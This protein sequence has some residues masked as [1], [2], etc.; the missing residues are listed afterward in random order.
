[1]ANIKYKPAQWEKA[2]AYYE[3]GLLLREVEEKTGI[4]LVAI[5]KMAKAKG[6]AKEGEKKIIL[7]Q[8]VG[9]AAAKA[10][11]DDVERK[12]HDELLLEKTKHITF[13]NNAALKNVS[14][15]IRKID[16]KTS[17]L[18]HKHLSDT[19]AKSREVVLGKPI[20]TAIQINNNMEKADKD[21]DVSN[22]SNETL[23]ELLAVKNQA[24]I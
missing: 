22:L 12:I 10:N 17:Q 20:D 14:V 23:N 9:L 11:F 5:S 18:D 1:M 21:I 3:A 4:P 6:W 24:G 8:A 7:Q 13:F 15:A 2:K 19:I 16:D